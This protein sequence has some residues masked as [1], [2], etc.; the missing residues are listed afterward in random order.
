MIFCKKSRKAL[1]I[2]LWK[3]G[4][5][6]NGQIQKALSGFYY[7]ETEDGIIYQTRGR[8]NFRAKKTSILVGDYVTFESTNA[9][10]GVIL[11]VESRRNELVRPAVANIDCAVIVMSAVEPAFSMHLLDKYLITLEQLDITPIIYVSK[12]DRHAPEELLDNLDYYRRI[13]YAVVLSNDTDALEQV[14]KL[15]KNQLS[16]LVGQSGAGKSTLLNKLLPELNLATQ[17]ISSYLNRGKHTTRHVEI[18]TVDNCRIADTPGFSAIDFFDMGVEELNTYFIDIHELSSLCKFR[19]CQHL[20]EPSCA[21]KEAAEQDEH[22]KKRY[23]H[24]VQ[25]YEEIKSKKKF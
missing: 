16:V 21:V 11:S 12:L 4:K 22:L 13:G 25:F 20:K 7:V 18:H 3:G 24:Y 2:V 19:G 15:L 5:S 17:E 10:E 6:I 8:G 14:K 1:F 9:K 23:A